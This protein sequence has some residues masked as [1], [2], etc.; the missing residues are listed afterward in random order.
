M[1]G[2][3]EKQHS[4]AKWTW[5]IKALMKINE[6]DNKW[7]WNKLRGIDDET[8]EWIKWI[9]RYIYKEPF[10]NMQQIRQDVSTLDVSRE[11]SSQWLRMTYLLV[12]F[13]DTLV[14]SLWPFLCSAGY[15]SG[16]H[17]VYVIVP[18]EPFRWCL[19]VQLIVSLSH[20]QWCTFNPFN[21]VL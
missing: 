7:Y 1:I 3:K 5:R 4:A 12:C 17:L 13:G 21:K 10:M 14:I 18:P 9:M 2:M 20:F 11:C 8:N 19:L 16:A 6:E 15:P